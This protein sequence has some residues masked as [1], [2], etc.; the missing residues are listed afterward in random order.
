MI[1]TIS[2]EIL[3]LREITEQRGQSMPES[4]RM[5]APQFS[6]GATSRCNYRNGSGLHIPIWLLL[7]RQYTGDAT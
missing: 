3:F 1:N 6:S 7:P 2:M 4:R 5:A